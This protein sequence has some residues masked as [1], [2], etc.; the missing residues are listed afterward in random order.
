M[1]NAL[2][3]FF[4][5]GLLFISAAGLA[6][7]HNSGMV[8][9]I[10]SGKTVELNAFSTNAHTFQWFKDGEVITNAN[11]SKINVSL[12]GE[13]T[14]QSFNLLNCSSEISKKVTVMVWPD[15]TT[16]ADLTIHKTAENKAIHISETFSYTINVENKGPDKA[17]NL[18]VTDSLPK[19]LEM[20]EIAYTANAFS[21]YNGQS[22]SITWE[23]DSLRVNEKMELTYLAKALYPG[24][25]TNVAYV[26]A[27]ETD[28]HILN[29]KTEAIKMIYGLK[30]P[31]VFTPNQ[32]NINDTYRIAGL[33]SF[34]ENEFTVLNRWG[35][36]VYEKKS[37]QNDWTGE[38]LHEGTYFYVLKI[39]SSTEKWEVF[40]GF[41]TLIRKKP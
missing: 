8:I 28:P 41:I 22:H 16:S 32:D 20:K 37:Y 2:I 1:K 13:Y 35:N 40:K 36:H 9:N 25:L 14:V 19:Q 34:P 27:N 29:N 5:S 12:S 31:N 30:F 17:S 11:T 33:E 18:I 3:I 15:L 4:C 23:I 7:I 26:K 6:Q 38:G 10:K 21:K 39:K 24:Q